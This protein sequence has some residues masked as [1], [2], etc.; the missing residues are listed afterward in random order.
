MNRRYILILHVCFWIL[1]ALVPELQMIFPD[2]KYPLSYYYHTYISI[3]INLINFYI[4]YYFISIDFLNVKKIVVNLLKTL[5][6]IVFFV[7]LRLGMLVVIYVYLSGFDY[8]EVQI[9]FYNIIVEVYYSITFTIM[10]L[11]IKFMI[12]WFN[13]QKQKSELQAKTTSSELALLR[14]QIN[15][16]FLFNT[17]N[18]LYSLVYKKSDEAP[19]VVMKLSEIMRYMLYDASSEKVLLDKEIGYLK[20]FIH[21][22]ELRLK[23]DNFTEFIIQGD[24]S[25]K[26]I[27]PMLLIPFVENAFKHGL[28][29]F[30]I[31]GIMIHMELSVN[32][33]DFDIRNYFSE[34][35][36]ISDRSTGGVGLE[37]VKRRLE[38]I[39]PAQHNLTFEITNEVYHVHLKIDKL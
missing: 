23:E 9:R 2:R 19:S 8:L 14:S 13:S 26:M 39:Y 30:R 17:L 37:N 24:V 22:N 25:D 27:P 34:S 7:A 21:L 4:C 16:H 6:V 11:L 38:I 35:G 3:G 18:N 31:P 33:L 20:S 29:K 32:R 28:K 5:G 10:A 1:F 15:P 36:K 12:D